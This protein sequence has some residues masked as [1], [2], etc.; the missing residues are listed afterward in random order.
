MRDGVAIPGATGNTYTTKQNDQGHNIT[1]SLTGLTYTPVAA[2]IA[3]ITNVTAAQN[4]P[5]HALLTVGAN[6]NVTTG[7]MQQEASGQVVAVRLCVA[8]KTLANQVL[9]QFKAVVATS[10]TVGGTGVNDTWQPNVNG[11]VYAAPVDSQGRGWVP[12]TWNGGNPN[13]TM[14][15]ATGDSAQTAN[16]VVRSDRIVLPSRPRKSGETGGPMFLARMEQMLPTGQWTY[17][18]AN[19]NAYAATIG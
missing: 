6:V 15:A 12:V 19:Y 3:N 17:V 11:V 8:S 9:P 5:N 18:N 4:V 7:C 10:D 13:F 1:Y 2:A 14:P 16:A